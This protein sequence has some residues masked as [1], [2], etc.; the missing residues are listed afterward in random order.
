MDLPKENPLRIDTLAGEIHEGAD[1]A[2][3]LLCR[4]DRFSKAHHRAVEMS[5]YAKVQ[6]DVKIFNKLQSCGNYL[7]FR[8]YYTV[9][10]VRLAAATFCKKHLLCPLC[11][12]RRGAKLVKA[13]LDKLEVIKA[14]NPTLKAYLVTLTVKDGEDLQERFNHLA[15]S[16]KQYHHRRHVKGVSCEAAK[17]LAA[18]WSYEF[19][20]GSG[21]CKWHPHIHAVWLCEEEPSQTRL[22][23]EWHHITGDSYIVD[24]TPFHDQQNVITGFLEVFKY[25]VKFSD[26]LLADN[27]HGYEILSNKRLIA[28][29]GL[30]RGVDVPESLTDELLDDLPYIE[31]LYKFM[32]GIGYSYQKK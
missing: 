2:S 29:F 1:D 26:L 24:I 13:Y 30:F 22:S 14:E 21:S 7:L 11:A 15:N 25:A 16:V 18:V 32:L 31:H 27:W 19:K 6:G 3:A 23:R 10:K 8:D 28:S 4:L 17:A 9:G 5:H 20:R 12:I